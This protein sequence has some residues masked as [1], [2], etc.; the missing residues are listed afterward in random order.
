MPQTLALKRTATPEEVPARTAETQTLGAGN[1]QRS[2]EQN[3]TE[4]EPS[5]FVGASV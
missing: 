3:S 1:K 5:T 2:R 4:I